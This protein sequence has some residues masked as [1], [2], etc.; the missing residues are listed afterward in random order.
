M[1]FEANDLMPFADAI[2]AGAEAISDGACRLSCVDAK[3]S[4]IFARLDRG[5]PA[6]TT[7]SGRRV[8]R[9][10]QHGGSREAQAELRHASSRIGMPVAI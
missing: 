1:S 7:D 10:H 3:P 2:G 4:R 5:Y 8:Q 6:T 9:R